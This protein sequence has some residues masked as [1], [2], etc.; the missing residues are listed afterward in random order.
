MTQA[1][2]R[3]PVRYNTRGAVLVGLVGGVLVVLV[4]ILVV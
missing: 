4:A 3:V 1:Q 2:A